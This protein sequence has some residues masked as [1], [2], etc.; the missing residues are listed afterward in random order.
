MRRLPPA[1]D[2]HAHVAPAIAPRELSALSA[3]VFAVTR[4]STEWD[5]VARRDDPTTVWGIGCHPKVKAA[6]AVFDA[7]RFSDFVSQFALIGEVGLDGRSALSMGQQRQTFDA[8]LGVLADQ[9]RIV[10][11]HSAGANGAVLEMLRQHGTRGA[12][13]HWWRGTRAQTETALELGCFFSCNGAEVNIPK[14]VDVVPR[15]RI[16]TETDFPHSRRT[17]PSADR[18]GAVS[19]I[20]QALANVWEC[21]SGD[22]RR[23]VWRNL[24]AVVD[25]TASADLLPH[26]VQGTLLRDLGDGLQKT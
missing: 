7:D 1:L 19:T 3:V 5:A 17:D 25:L 9:P 14:V 12:I 23:Q 2:T 4:S 10:T 18:P 22:V 8:V 16:L 15:S 24:R 11:I 21:E 20:E 13:L 26:E 6:H